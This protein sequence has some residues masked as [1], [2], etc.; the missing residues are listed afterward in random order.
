MNPKSLEECLKSGTARPDPLKEDG[1]EP[2]YVWNPDTTKYDAHP[3]MDWEL[4]RNLSEKYS[5]FENGGELTFTTSDGETVKLTKKDKA[6]LERIIAERKAEEKRLKAVPYEVIADRK[7]LVFLASNGSD[8][9]YFT[10]IPESGGLYKLSGYNTQTDTW[11]HSEY[12]V[13]ALEGAFAS[14]AGLLCI[15]RKEEGEDPDIV[16]RV[17]SSDLKT[18]V[19]SYTDAA[20]KFPINACATETAL[21]VAHLTQGQ[22]EL[23]RIDFANPTHPAKI[24]CNY[25]AVRNSCYVSNSTIGVLADQC[26]VFYTFYKN[27]IH[28]T[29]ISHPKEYQ[30]DKHGS[31]CSP[32]E[33]KRVLSFRVDPA[34][35]TLILL[36]TD[37]VF[38]RSIEDTKGPWLNIRM[39]GILDAAIVAE[40]KAYLLHTAN[41]VTV[42]D[43]SNGLKPECD[44]I[45]YTPDDG[46]H[47]CHNPLQIDTSILSFTGSG[48]V[49]IPMPTQKVFQITETW[50]T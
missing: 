40:K 10:A 23:V 19:F 27:K 2:D 11:L 39:A 31:A 47:A 35:M 1:E 33:F 50:M 29:R 26:T 45:T 34:T 43:I 41:E 21:W 14:R 8:M 38:M 4:M 13:S 5:E 46:V 48:H 15:D 16:F 3:R 37:N 18:E 30:G 25:R 44:S 36:G 22:K 20:L 28:A 24:E 42:V 9:L 12:F 17:F 7:D 49:V 32:D 6:E